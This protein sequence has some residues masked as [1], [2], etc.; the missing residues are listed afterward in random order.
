M[1]ASSPGN[2]EQHA[3]EQPEEM[4]WL[5]EWVSSAR[6]S[7]SSSPLVN[8]VPPAWNAPGSRP[9]GV[10]TFCQRAMPFRL[11]P[12]RAVSRFD[13]NFWMGEGGRRQRKKTPECWGQTI[14]QF[15]PWNLGAAVLGVS[16]PICSG[17]LGPKPRAYRGQ[18]PAPGK[19]DKP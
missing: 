4:S 19:V 6:L 3:I 12:R 14:G 2:Q 8:H 5:P 15:R 17:C 7:R 9:P 1:H 16:N 11:E 10:D 18:T 13:R